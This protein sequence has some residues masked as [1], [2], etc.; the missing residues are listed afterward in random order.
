MKRQHYL[1]IAIVAIAVMGQTGKLTAQELAI[2]HGPWLQNLTG[3]GITVMWTTNHP[4]V[5]A[6]LI[7]SDGVTFKPVQN[8]TDG[9][10]DAGDT[11]HKVRV[12]GLMPGKEYFYQVYSRSIDV[13][14]AY[15][16]TYKDTLVSAIHRFRTIDPASTTVSFTVLNDVHENSAKMAG[17]L[18][19]SSIK[20]PDIL[21]FNGDMIDYLQNRSQI[22]E[23]FLDTAVHYFAKSTPFVYVRGNHEARGRLAR[24][25]KDYFDY[26]E[27]RFYG[28][29]RMGP[30]Q[31][32]I[33]DCGEDKP[34]DNQYYFQLADYDRY[35]LQQLDW[36]K[37]EIVK[38]E[39][40]TARFRV[41]IIHMPVIK[42]SDQ[43][44]GMKVLAEEFGPVLS[45]AGIDL[46]LSGHTHKFSALSPS[47]A[48]FGYPVVVASNNNF[49]EVK[50][51]KSRMVV[52]VRDTEGK[53][54]YRADNF[55]KDGGK[56][57]LPASRDR[58][59]YK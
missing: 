17:Y 11:L 35:R 23:G 59:S 12:E 26:P 41:V 39:F 7:S 57:V 54:L 38:P 24:Q 53:E 10:I 31:F 52:V 16:I 20:N 8:S 44:H 43:W 5:P 51:D 50:V 15:K 33:L 28:S 9:M 36:L 47:E 6:V 48:G 42:G 27:D 58:N 55:G 25:F 4:S 18:E 1:K 49:I 29:F 14:Q 45:T 19:N 2:S 32:L 56:P 30:V 40:T 21:F 22:F 13:F 37:N 34:D 46:M 3:T